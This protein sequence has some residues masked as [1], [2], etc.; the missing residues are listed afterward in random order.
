MYKKWDNK[1]FYL[2]EV[3]AKRDGFAWENLNEGF[4]ELYLENA[5]E[6]LKGLEKCSNE[7]Q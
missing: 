6:I 5:E 3:L 2:A 4:L 1:T 7:S